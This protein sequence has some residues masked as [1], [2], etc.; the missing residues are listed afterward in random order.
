MYLGKVLIGVIALG[1]ASVAAVAQEDDAGHGSDY[2][3]FSADGVGLGK[4][5]QR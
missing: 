1:C 4:P 5:P 3:T 2:R